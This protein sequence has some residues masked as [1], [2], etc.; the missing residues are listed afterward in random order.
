MN[1]ILREILQQIEQAIN[2]KIDRLRGL[3]D[4]KA[5]IITALNN[6]NAALKKTI[7]RR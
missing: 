5:D 7:S 4:R 3:L 6:E 2:D 1:E